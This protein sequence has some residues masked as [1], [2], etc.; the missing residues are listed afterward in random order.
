VV[1]PG[2]MRVLS[3]FLFEAIWG[4]LAAYNLWGK[5][6]A[7]AGRRAMRMPVRLPCVPSASM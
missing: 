1:L 2:S 5:L 7:Y 6:A 4:M 3:Q